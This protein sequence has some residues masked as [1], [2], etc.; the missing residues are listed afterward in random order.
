ME[1]GHAARGVSEARVGVIEDAE[2][3]AWCGWL[4]S[5]RLRLVPHCEEASAAQQVSPQ[6]YRTA[7]L[8]ACHPHWKRRQIEELCTQSVVLTCCTVPLLTTIQECC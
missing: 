7:A 5:D 3:R 1:A 4:P 6:R 8:H 2:D